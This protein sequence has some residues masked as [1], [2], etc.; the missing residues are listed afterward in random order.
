MHAVRTS[1]LR[2]FK[3]LN[4]KPKTQ[5]PLQK[6]TKKCLF[7]FIQRFNKAVITLQALISQFST[8][9]TFEQHQ[10]LYR[11]DIFKWGRQKVRKLSKNLEKEIGGEN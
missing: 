2:G 1:C 5:N 6:I 3:T 10:K 4:P 11:S 7:A 8:V 9:P